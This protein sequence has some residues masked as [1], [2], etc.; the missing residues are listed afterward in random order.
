M[1]SRRT[2]FAAPRAALLAS[3]ALV[4]SVFAVPA[5]AN[6]IT[7]A[8][9][10]F[11]ITDTVP[12]SVT[13]G[14]AP[15]QATLTFSN[16][17][18]G[19]GTFSTQIQ[20]QNQTSAALFPSARLTDFGFNTQ[21]NATG[22]SDTSAIFTTFLNSNLPSVGIVDVCASTGPTCAGGGGGDLAPGASNTFTLTL[23]GLPANTISVELGANTLGSPTET[24]FFK[25]QTAIG[26]FESSCV[27]GGSCTTNVPEPMSVA[28]L[29]AGLLGLGLVRRRAQK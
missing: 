6:L 4:A 10:S 18:F 13:G 5:S 22:V 25:W 24:Y 20:V 7:A 27:F 29:G 8:S 23:T 17:T 1:N 16:F 21:P 15:L 2:P 26:S 9:S 28:L 19:A 12:T 14:P 11:S 3:A